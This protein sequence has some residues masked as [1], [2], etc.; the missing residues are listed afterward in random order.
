MIALGVLLGLMIGALVMMALLPSATET[1]TPRVGSGVAFLRDV[2]ELADL[3]YANQADTERGT[4]VN[5]I[6]ASFEAQWPCM[7]GEFATGTLRTWKMHWDRMKVFVPFFCSFFLFAVFW[8]GGIHCGSGDRMGGS[9][10]VG[11]R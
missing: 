5:T 1:H 6:I 4:R 7:W 10:R 11:W 2:E 9:S 8:R 3:V